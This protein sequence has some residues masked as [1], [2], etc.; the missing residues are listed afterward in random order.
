MRVSE[1]K[2]SEASGPVRNIVFLCFFG[3]FGRFFS[4][5]TRVSLRLPKIRGAKF[6]GSFQ[7]IRA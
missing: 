2:A 5:Y 1:C 7:L 6:I 4:T 3:R